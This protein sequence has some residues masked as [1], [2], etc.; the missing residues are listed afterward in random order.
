MKL[1]IGRIG[2][3]NVHLVRNVPHVKNPPVGGRLQSFGRSGSP[4]VHIQG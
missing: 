4:W 3:C 1:E 2:M